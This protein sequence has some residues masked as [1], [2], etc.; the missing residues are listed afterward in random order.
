MNGRCYDGHPFADLG[1]EQSADHGK[2]Y[3][4]GLFEA[5]PA[6]STVTRNGVRI[7]LQDQPFQ[8]LSFL[9]ERPGEIVS[10]EELRQRLWPEGT[11]VDFDGSL[12]VI[13]KR[14]RTALSDDPESPRY[15]QTVP[16]R[17][18]RFIAPVSVIEKYPQAVGG[19]TSGAAVATAAKAIQPSSFLGS[20]ASIPLKESRSRRPF[21]YAASACAM[22][23]TA[24]MVLAG[25]HHGLPIM[26]SF[27]RTP[28]VQTRKSVAVLG[29]RNLSGRSEDAWLSTALSEMLSTELAG[30]EKLR[31]V[32][33]EDIANLRAAAPWSGAD[34]LDRSTSTRVSGALNSDVLVL[35]SY[36]L[37]GGSDNGQL[38]L[39]VRMQDGKTGEIV[40]ETAQSGNAHDLFRLV[41]QI[42]AQL[43]SSLGVE[44]LQSSEEAGVVASLPLDPQAARF[45][46]L[47][48]TKL[49]QFDALAA[50]DLLERAEEADPNFSLVHAMLAR[51]WAQLGYGQ[52]HQEEAKKAF[53]LSSDL[54]RAQRLLVEG[55]YYESLGKQEQAASV[56]HALYELFPDNV[57][58]ALRLVAVQTLAGHG[59]R[60]MEVIKKLRALPPP[61]SEDPR[62]DL[63]EARA[64]KD[65]KVASLAVVRNAIRKANTR[66]QK[67]IYATARKEECMILIYGAQPDQGPA[68][69]EEAYNIFL[70]AGNRV[71]A[72]DAVRLLG[73]GLG[74]EGR[75]QQAIETY[76]R[77]LSLLD[78]MEEHE[79]SGSIMNNM[80]INF[81]N[82]GDLNRAEQLYRQARLQFQE[83]G[84]AQNQST[85]ISNI[86]DILFLRGDLTG[87]E[88]LYQDAL[89]LIA[90]MDNS[91]PGYIYT[92]LADIR[93]DQGRI[94]EARHLAQD[95]IA[96][97]APIHGAYTELSTAVMELGSVLEAQGDMAG[98]RVQFQR[99]LEMQQKMKE[100]ELAA[101]SQ[102]ALAAVSI[103]EGHG[104]EAESLLRTALA[105]FEKEK[106]DP[107]SSS[108]YTLL[109]RAL[110]L[111]GRVDDAR[112]AALR[113]EALSHTSADPALRLPAEIQLARVELA[114]A[115]GDAARLAAVARRLH[116][117][118][119]SAK[120]MGYSNLE[121]E[122]RLV[123][124]NAEV[125]V[126][127]SVGR[128]Q[129]KSLA[130]ETRNSG[131]EL[132]ARE[133]EESLSAGTVVAQAR[134][135][136]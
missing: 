129:L 88:K 24:V 103:E 22:L 87:A 26:Q 112:N 41:S 54:P 67:L 106:S 59:A 71:A 111:Q 135:V 126:N 21:W 78:G 115:G 9:L 133:A 27:A 136:H 62:I 16:R 90:A 7:K 40:Y 132:L 18:Y 93:L 12:N 42:G 44:A 91:E 99:A 2:I 69:C 30:G 124:A 25:S 20:A 116:A 13:L 32:S 10:R 66:G 29:F 8:L 4:F 38:R 114:S 52:K 47:G 104:E 134:V 48:L 31:L 63:A 56:Y 81:T 92:R 19:Q 122:A 74:S 14:L 55:E 80:A 11:Y 50:K 125:K 86:A 82:E 95:A 105:Q 120:R 36:M 109:S 1:M 73:D 5:D 51:A 17:G 107:D 64:M 96:S 100:L 84:S 98:A 15:I 123:L 89:K 61:S 118:I 37:L 35:G 79:K 33:G 58:Y 131:Y 43:R 72:A 119:A 108:A 101:E 97:Y 6:T 110:L 34:S 53:D 65:D 75:F 46:S 60:A 76:Q 23:L 128:R 102:S 121:W 70:G 127:S 3:R 39:D 113:G 94:Q 117:A 68:A 28:F 130:S 45:Y 57:E 85:A 83:S 49:R 77:A